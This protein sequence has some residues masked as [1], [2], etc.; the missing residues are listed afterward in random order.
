MLGW[1]YE[2]RGR[3][4]FPAVVG[5]AC[6]RMLDFRW[7]ITRRVY[8]EEGVVAEITEGFGQKAEV[9]VPEELVGADSEVGVEEN[10]QGIGR[11]M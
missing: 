1:C 6:A 4:F 2:G 5:R 8:D 3:G 11:I 7:G 10:F 9:T